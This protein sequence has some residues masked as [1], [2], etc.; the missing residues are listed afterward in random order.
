MS[1]GERGPASM[2][3]D[4]DPTT[5]GHSD[6]SRGEG[7]SSFPSSS[8][9]ADAGGGAGAS[10]ARSRPCPYTDVRTVDQRSSH[11]GAA[12]ATAPAA[13]SSAAPAPGTGP[14]PDSWQE[15][16]LT[17]LSNVLPPG[18][19][20]AWVEAQETGRPVRGYEPGVPHP[21]EDLTPSTCPC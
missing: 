20:R 4:V 11:G 13:S 9:A 7:P 21:E 16:T 6:L 19:P 10:G 17:F 18:T 5:P 1:S 15:R 8:G 12:A 14:W 2:S 3:L